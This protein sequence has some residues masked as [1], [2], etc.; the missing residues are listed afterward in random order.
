MLGTTTYPGTP[1]IAIT[2]ILDPQQETYP[3]KYNIVFTSL[4]S[5]STTYII[6]IVDRYYRNVA[7]TF[8]QVCIYVDGLCRIALTTVNRELLN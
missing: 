6:I 8:P 7:I 5:P 3:I 2:S 4:S 1:L